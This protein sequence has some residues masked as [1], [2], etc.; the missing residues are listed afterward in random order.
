[1]T[2]ISNPSSTIPARVSRRKRVLHGVSA[3]A[4]CVALGTPQVANAVDAGAT[5]GDTMEYTVEL[6][7]APNGWAVRYKYKTTDGVA[8][9]DDDYE[10]TTGTVTF[11]SG[12]K[13]KKIYV[14]TVDDNVEEESEGFK[15]ELYDQEVNGLYRGVTGWVTPTDSIRGM[16]KTMSFTGQIL[17]ND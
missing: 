3:L 12:V 8:V 5:E 9:K 16:S 4:M 13:Q 15:L 11:N 2:D 7:V 6:G 14:E 17:D 1:M 10:E